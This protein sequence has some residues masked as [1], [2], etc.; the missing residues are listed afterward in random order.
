MNGGRIPRTQDP[1]GLA[2]EP[3]GR[4]RPRS[5]KADRAIL[6]AATGLLAERGPGGMSMEEVARQAV[7]LIVAGVAAAGPRA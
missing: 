7:E 1:R 3:P 6:A 2:A 4:G 5:E